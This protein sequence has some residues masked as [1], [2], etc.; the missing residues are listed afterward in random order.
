MIPGDRVTLSQIPPK[1]QIEPSIVGQW[2]H[3]I[4][5]SNGRA[6]I[7]LENGT[8]L[9]QIQIRYLSATEVASL[10]TP[11]PIERQLYKTDAEQLEE[12]RKALKEMPYRDNKAVQQARL[13]LHRQQAEILKR[14]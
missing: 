12:I 8:F 14:M 7:R 3:I 13:L 10:V 9:R 5:I 2:G 11:Q 1:R 6:N 4:D